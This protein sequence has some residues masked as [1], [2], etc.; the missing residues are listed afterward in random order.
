MY[1]ISTP[2]SDGTQATALVTETSGARTLDTQEQGAYITMLGDAKA[3]PW[4]WFWLLVRQ[5]WER[6]NDLSARMGREAD[7]AADSVV[8]RL[9]EGLAPAVEQA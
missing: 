4:D 9:Q 8:A 5:A 7:E 3:Y 2:L 1:L 6:Y